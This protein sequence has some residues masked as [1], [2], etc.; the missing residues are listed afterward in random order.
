[1]DRKERAWIEVDLQALKHNVS[2]LRRIMQPGCELMAVVKADAY[3]HGAEMVAKTLSELGVHAFATATIEEAIR[4][5]TCG[6]TGEILILGYTRAERAGDLEYYGLRQTVTDI[7]H[8]RA[9]DRMGRNIQT[10]IKIDTGMHR[11]G[12]CAENLEEVEEIFRM[13]H[14]QICGIFTHLCVADSL[15]EEDIRYTRKQIESFYTLLSKLARQGI[16]LPKIHV[17]S[18]YGLLNYPEFT[19][20][21][22]RIG[23]ALYGTLSDEADVVRTDISLR[24]ALEI[25]SAIVSVRQIRKGET[26]GYGRAFTAKRNSSIA[27][28]SIGY[29]DGIPRILSENHMEVLI[30]G[31]RVPV[32]GRICMDQLLVDVTDLA[33]IQAGEV[34]TLVGHDGDETI[35]VTEVAGKAGTIANEILSRV[36]QRLPK[37]YK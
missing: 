8:A 1:M 26:A 6:I 15:D 21:Y 12:T 31:K 32:I 19:C 10:D 18:S 4:L 25:K 9:L 30:R 13:E 37:I 3:G 35:P 34:V 36:G 33:D 11:L 22:A 29:G 23:I 17:Q 16:K 14:L 2:E 27:A 5:R 20:D 7:A 24:P 28:V